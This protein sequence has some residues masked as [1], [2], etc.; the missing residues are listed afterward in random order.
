MH[1]KIQKNA[2]IIVGVIGF[3]LLVLMVTVESEPGAIPL[4]LL[5]VS[6]IGYVSGRKRE[7]SST[8]KQKR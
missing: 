1:P 8:P 3:V 6:V 2:S 7:N 5:L 4:A